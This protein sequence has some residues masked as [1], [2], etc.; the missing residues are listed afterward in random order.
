MLC[1]LPCSD[2]LIVVLVYVLHGI[3]HRNGIRSQLTFYNVMKH[4][5]SLLNFSVR[6]KIGLEQIK[7]GVVVT[8]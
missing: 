3:R 4:I 6:L 2:L 8:P 7:D 1:I 5:V